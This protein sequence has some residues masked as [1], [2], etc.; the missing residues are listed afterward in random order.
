MRAQKCFL[1]FPLDHTMC[2]QT[3]ELLIVLFQFFLIGNGAIGKTI[4]QMVILSFSIS[5]CSV[6]GK[7][8]VVSWSK[9]K[10]SKLI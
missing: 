2:Q 5:D 10:K 1:P 6:L 3:E 4:V 8:C 7:C 9:K